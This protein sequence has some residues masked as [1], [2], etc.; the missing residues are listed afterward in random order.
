MGLVELLLVGARSRVG[1]RHASPGPSASRRQTLNTLA[2][3]QAP[4]TRK[5][6][7]V[8]ILDVL[9]VHFYPQFQGAGISL[10]GETGPEAAARRIR[11]TRSLWDPTYKDES[12]I[13]DTIMLIPRMKSWI[14]ENAPGM[15]ISIGEWNFGAERHMSG[16]F[17]VAET[18][19]HLGLEGI[20]SAFYWDRPRQG[21]L[22]FHAFRAFRNYD[23]QGARF[24][25]ASAPVGSLDG[26]LVAFASRDVRSEKVVAVLLN[27][28]PT[29]AAEVA[30]ATPGCGALGQTRSY[31]L[32]ANTDGLQQQP[33]SSM[34]QTIPP[35]SILVLELQLEPG[36][37]K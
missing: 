20:Y 17:A 22:A 36:A 12:W 35:Y 8:R 32:N 5:R 29:H 37:P 3:R 21:S 7:G 34:V 1:R 14:A 18:L 31:L 10:S 4:R 25:D 15:K 16:A 11:S 30:V 28:S 24:L 13:A 6:T 33:G 9:D 27:E 23:G 2:A 19:G 26:R